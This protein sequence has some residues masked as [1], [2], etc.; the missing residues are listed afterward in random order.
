MLI[1]AAPDVGKELS[2][3]LDGG[4]GVRHTDPYEALL[5]MQRRRWSTVL[6]T[7]PRPDFAGLCRA[8]RRLQPD[9][10]LLSVCGPA[11]E[12]EV[13][14]LLR[15]PL[16]DYFIPPLSRSDM[17]S[18]RAAAGA[19]P[20][21]PSADRGDAGAILTPGEF[22][23]LATSAG[24]IGMLERR[25]VELIGERISRPVAWAD[26]D[27]AGDQSALLRTEGERPRV[28]VPTDGAGAIDARATELIAAVRQCLPALVA[29]AKRTESL[30]TLAIT[31]HLTGTYNRRYFYHVIGRILAK[32]EQKQFPATLLLYDIDDFKRYNDTYGYAAGDDILRETAAL[33]KQSTRSQ[34]I[35]ARI[36]GDEFAVLFWEP[37]RPRSPD[38]RPP[39][40]AYVLADRFRQAVAAHSF[41]SLGPE[42]V[43]ALTISGGL[44]NF[45]RDGRS[46]R[47]L[48]RHAD[49]AIKAAKASGKNGIS[50]VGK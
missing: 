43:G 23:D 13:R 20:A 36:G 9:T 7:A 2:S 3:C 6:L 34:D 49:T 16:D 33:M 11:A 46:C 15:R 18:V 31:D 41:E 32:A 42:A 39:E 28:L 47:E 30:H 4:Q 12:P 8:A 19:G 45:P 17:A 27:E 44:A 26:A 14:A 29:T 40:T 1:L 35:V 24:T 48:L 10:K 5:E 37:G 38:S 25:L 22:A 21:A 50:L